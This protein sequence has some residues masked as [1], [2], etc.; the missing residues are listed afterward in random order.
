MKNN[1]YTQQQIKKNRR[2]CKVLSAMLVIFMFLSTAL[3]T[4]S[5]RTNSWNLNV[6]QADGSEYF[7]SVGY[8]GSPRPQWSVVRQNCFILCKR[9]T[10]AFNS[11]ITEYDDDLNV[12]KILEWLYDNGQAS[13]AVELGTKWN[14]FNAHVTNF[15]N[16]TSELVGYSDSVPT[17][18]GKEVTVEQY[19]NLY[20]RI[21]TELESLNAY[22]SDVRSNYQASKISSDGGMS[23][24]MIDS[25]S[26]VN[27]L[28]TQL[29]VIISDVGFGS[30]NTNRFLGISTSSDSIRS[31]ADSVA[32]VTKTFAYAIAVILFGVNITTTALQN[33]ILTLRGGIKVFA[34]V[35]LVKIWIDLAIPICMYALGIVNSLARQILTTLSSGSGSVFGNSS[36]NSSSAS[37]WGAILKM[38]TRI[39]NTIVEFITG[40]PSLILIIIMIVCIVLV[41]IKLVA[42]CFELTCLVSLSPIFFATLVGEE[43]KRYFR[44]FMS[45]FLSTSGYIAYV[46]IV[47]AVGTRWV[48]QATEPN[49]ATSLSALFLPII[50]TLPRAIIIIACCRVM[51]KPP[52]VLLSLTDGG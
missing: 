5:A 42:R 32:G 39:F 10:T 47:Y 25:G 51:V 27:Y 46:A 24:A 34:R 49:L 40:F 35:I 50:S 21:N 2:L 9:L 41:I 43:S 44:R 6:S 36:I 14:V 20:S 18:N 11:C 48:A 23:G 52:K 45:A 4:V 19:Q 16:E 7:Y 26:I 38:V 17:V 1:I 28:W 29:R 13:N 12:I 33:E 30:G 15:I 37:G 8:G 3:L 31:I 22:V